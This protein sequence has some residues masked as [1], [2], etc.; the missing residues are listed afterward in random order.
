MEMLLGLDMLKRH[1]CTID[2]RRNVLVIGTTGT[3]TA[4][5]PENELPM[6]ARM[7]DEPTE[8]E[9]KLLGASSKSSQGSERN[10]GSGASTSSSATS[11]SAGAIRSILDAPPLNQSGTSSGADQQ[12]V[13]QL[14][15]MGFPRELA[16]RMLAQFNGNLDQA[17]AAL[18]AASLPPPPKQGNN[19][20]TKTT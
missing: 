17:V 2:L 20:N 15:S 8:A 7:S 13:E 11:S 5:L 3:E 6:S 14:V 16:T 1:Q 9:L 18:L 4:F 12:K 19:N 10:P